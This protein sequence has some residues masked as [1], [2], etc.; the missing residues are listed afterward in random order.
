MPVDVTILKRRELVER[1]RI[2]G[3]YA[4]EIHELRKSD[5]FRMIAQADEVIGG[6]RSAGCLEHRRRH[7]GG[8]LHAKVHRRALRRRQ[9]IADAF[10][11]EHVG[12]LVRVADRSGD[13]VRKDAAVEL[14]RRHQRQFDME[15][16]VDETRDAGKAAPVDLALPLVARMRAD[17]AVADDC[18]VAPRHRPGDD[19][20]E[21]DV[22]QHQ[23]GRH[24]A[25]ARRDRAGKECQGF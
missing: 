6:E 7:T 4:G 13:T 8:E 10:K 20:E 5:D 17:D 9:E 22:A 12:D 15:M 14:E 25:R 23:V 16:C 24:T 2:G 18:N 1:C 19:V 3:K 11:P 21:I